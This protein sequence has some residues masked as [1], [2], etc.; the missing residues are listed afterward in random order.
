MKLF[1]IEQQLTKEQLLNDCAS[2][3]ARM[4]PTQMLF[5]GI[6]DDQD[7]TISIV[8][9]TRLPKDSASMQHNFFN[10][11]IQLADKVAN[12][13]NSAFVTGDVDFATRYGRSYVFLPIGNFNYTWML[14]N[15]DWTLDIGV[16]DIADALQ[17]ADDNE[18]LKNIY[19][20][21]R[22]S[23]LKTFLE[24][25]FSDEASI[26]WTRRIF[27]YLLSSKYLI[28]EYGLPRTKSIMQYVNRIRG[29]DNTLN[30]ARGT[31]NEIMIHCDKYY[32][33]QPTLYSSLFK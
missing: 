10:Y 17:H 19:N 33:I 20:T 1:E 2:W 26:G 7:W 5:R 31:G 27:N 14:H 12:R 29:D 11:I 22:D 15:K 23:R 21:T 8:N 13:S 32:M 24:H 3:F 28:E 25:Q 6:Y 4:K 16:S 18:Y 9:Q 30:T